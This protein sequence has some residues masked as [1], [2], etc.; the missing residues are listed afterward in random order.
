[1][2]R[3]NS[4]G[5]METSNRNR[6]SLV[7]V[8]VVNYNG[9]Q[10]L[11]ACIGAL[12]A[13]SDAVQEIIVVDNAST[14]DSS[15]ILREIATEHPEVRVLSSEANL[16]YAGAVNLALATAS[17][18][19]L[20]IMNMDITVE[21]GWLKPL[22]AFLDQTPDAG[23]VNPVIMLPDGSRINAAGLD[24]HV[25]GLGFTRGLWS[26]VAGLDPSPVRVSGI[27]GAVFVMRRQLL[28]Q[29]GGMDSSGFLYHEDVN[30]SWLL[31]MAGF[32][33]YCVPESRVRHDYSLTMYPAKLYLLERNRWAMLLTYLRPM[34]LVLLS[35]LLIITE[36]VMWCYCILRGWS[37]VRSKFESYRWVAGMLG[38]IQKRRQS[39]ESA[40]KVSDW[41]VIRKLK[42]GYAWKQ[43]LAIGRERGMSRRQV[44]R[45]LSTEHFD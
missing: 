21:P 45:G 34:T 15:R 28:D 41:E 8:I 10:W 11:R 38:T 5:T 42:W 35:P 12:L 40:R 1:M 29:I 13:D 32:Y 20:A 36:M 4:A 9:E 33:L 43:L 22:I 17:A 7:S 6:E 37:F 44:T 24:V 30:L 14:D 23:A 31:H 25:T 16:G 19:Y 18:K 39:T 26:P 27:S 2:N 3:F